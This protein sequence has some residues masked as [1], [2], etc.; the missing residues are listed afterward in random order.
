MDFY[1]FDVE[2]GQSA[3]IRLPNGRSCLFDAG[4]SS[5]FSPTA[6]IRAEQAKLRA[7]VR[8]AQLAMIGARRP[9]PAP[10]NPFAL[11]ALSALTPTATVAEPQFSYLK[12]TISHLHHDHLSDWGAMFGASP[13]FLRTVDYDRDYLIDVRDSSSTSSFPSVIAFCQSY[14]GGFGPATV[15]PN[16]GGALISELSLPVS[17]ARILG[18]DANSR[19]NNASVVTRIDCYGNSIL[20]CGDMEQ[21]AWDFVLNPVHGF[22]NWR[23][24]VANVDVLV[25]PHHG[26]SSAY[27]TRLLALARPKVVLVSVKSYDEH[28]DERYSSD[29]I[30]G[31]L[32]GQEEFKRITTRKKGTIRV[33]IAPPQVFGGKGKR[34][35]TFEN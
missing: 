33:T 12:A 31:M 24:L 14:S 17:V 23:S 11:S 18:G 35:W 3:A 5:G 22:T 21:D 15:V 25:A 20:I 9:A 29:A 1:L 30:S 10:T 8:A 26:H 16:Y 27:S 34:T 32:I 4:S 2:H 28:V 6:F 13:Q 19:V 7:A